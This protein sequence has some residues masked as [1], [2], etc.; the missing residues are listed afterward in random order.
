LPKGKL[1]DEES[2][3]RR[4]IGIRALHYWG[5]RSS[6]ALPELLSLLVTESQVETVQEIVLA[7]VSIGP[8]AIPHVI[9]LLTSSRLHDRF[10]AQTVLIQIGESSV[11][12][13][14][15]ALL[16][17]SDPLCQSCA[18]AVL[19]AIGNKASQA[20]AALTEL[21]LDRNDW[22]VRG[23]ILAI[24]EIGPTAT[25]AAPQLVQLLFHNSDDIQGTAR[26][27]LLKLGVGAMKAIQEFV[28]TGNDDGRCASIATQIGEA[29]GNTPASL[30]TLVGKRDEKDE[31]IFYWICK[32]LV[33]GDNSLRSVGKSMRKLQ[34]E[35]AIPRSLPCSDSKIRSTLNDLE[36][37]LTEQFG[38]TVGVKL[39]ER[40]HAKLFEITELGRKLY[41]D[42]DRKIR[43]GKSRL[44]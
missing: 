27:S 33:D 12:Q 22:L 17:H 5:A 39:I 35:G 24:G 41:L 29:L 31:M 28:D 13:V 37:R 6:Y 2:Q 20:V 43:K 38:S 7:I 30:S 9:S 25:A 8:A 15:L 21:L 23:A 16:E 3:E 18:L 10:C 34:E 26:A 19:A 1:L 32:L 42:I 11:E 4:A 14:V 40:R 36:T 44:S